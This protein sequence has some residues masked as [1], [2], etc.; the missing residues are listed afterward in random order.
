MVSTEEKSILLKLKEET[1]LGHPDSKYAT[2]AMYNWMKSLA[3]IIDSSD[4]FTHD[5]LVKLYSGKP[6]LKVEEDA[7]FIALTFDNVMMALNYHS[8]LKAMLNHSN[9]SDFLVNGV[10]SWYYSI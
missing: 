7:K 3:M 5:N 1:G 10:I 2:P 8:S 9:H 4:D 6:R